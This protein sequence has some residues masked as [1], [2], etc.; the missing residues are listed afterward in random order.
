MHLATQPLSGY[1]QTVVAK[2]VEGRLTHPRTL[3]P[4]AEHQ[5]PSALDGAGNSG[6]GGVGELQGAGATGH[7]PEGQSGGG[8]GS[9][10]EGGCEGPPSSSSPSS[11]SDGGGLGAGARLRAVLQR[12]WRRARATLGPWWPTRIK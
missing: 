7:D 8:R 6:G 11:S 10:G 9:E 4:P 3:D 1:V 2:V 12:H 5:L